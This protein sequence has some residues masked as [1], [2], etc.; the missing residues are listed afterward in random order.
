M[1]ES[2]RLCLPLIGHLHVEVSSIQR[3]T[4]LNSRSGSKEILKFCSKVSAVFR[5]K[6]IRFF[7]NSHN[8]NC[9]HKKRYLAIPLFNYSIIVTEYAGIVSVPSSNVAVASADVKSTLPI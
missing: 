1:L 5:F 3:D 7:L 2:S 9:T 4:A 8:K 6:K